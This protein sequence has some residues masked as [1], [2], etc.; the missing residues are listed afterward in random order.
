MDRWLAS[1]G[2]EGIEE[3]WRE[4]NQVSLDGLPTHILDED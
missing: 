2:D 4:Q 3:Y 1:R